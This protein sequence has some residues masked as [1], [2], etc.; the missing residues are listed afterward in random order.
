MAW[1]PLK[2]FNLLIFKRKFSVHIFFVINTKKLLLMGFN[3]GVTSYLEL[4]L[5]TKI[6]TKRNNNVNFAR[7]VSIAY[8]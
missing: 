4:S 8:V 2:K 7:I 1:N 6:G 5:G 3:R